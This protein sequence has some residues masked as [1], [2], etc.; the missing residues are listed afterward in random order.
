MFLSSLAV[1]YPDEVLTNADLAAM[2][3][4]SDAWIVDRVGIRE[5]RRSS[6]DM[7][8]H[9]LGARAAVQTLADHDPAAVDLVVCA[10]SISDYHIPATAN[11]VGAAVGCGDAAAFDLRAGCSGF[12]F[13]LHV[14]RGLIGSAHQRALL[15]IPEAYT[16][17]TDYQDRSTCVLW[18]DAAFACL[19]TPQPPPGRSFQVLDTF[20]GSRSKDATAIEVPVGGWF[21]QKGGAVQT[22]AIRKMTEVVQTVLDRQGLAAADVGYLIGHQANLGILTRVAER[23]GFTS[24]QHLTN[25][26]LFGNCGAA[27]APAVLAQNA[28]GFQDGD[29]IVVATVGAGLSWGGAMLVAR[30]S[31]IP[32][33]EGQLQ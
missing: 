11:L 7:P 1:W 12:V 6:P 9:V 18:G 28:R 19:V 8:V 14:L 13:A 25:I 17:A 4:T 31:D 30:D 24:R 23:T 5:R 32:K 26:E 27:G 21:R 16:H 29:R 22:F 15:V 33:G 3:D 2:V 10:P 20:I